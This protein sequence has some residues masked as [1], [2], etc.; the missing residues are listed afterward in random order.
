MLKLLDL[1]LRFDPSFIL[2][3]LLFI[4]FQ[5]FIL[6]F[7]LGRGGMHLCLVEM[8]EG[9][10]GPIEIYLYLYIAIFFAF[11]LHV[12]CFHFA[13]SLANAHQMTVGAPIFAFALGV[14]NPLGGPACSHK[15]SC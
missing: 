9:S 5:S 7:N 4:P 12:N 8:L 11:F 1:T 3:I 2:T 13:G 15:K 14:Q 6:D 10:G